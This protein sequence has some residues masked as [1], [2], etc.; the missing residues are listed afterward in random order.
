MTEEIQMP[1][2]SSLIHWRTNQPA[3]FM[4]YLTWATD[5]YTHD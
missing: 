5:G 1:L 2:Q 3:N 4:I